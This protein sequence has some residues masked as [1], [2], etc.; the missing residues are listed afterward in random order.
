[1]A[2][3]L[4]KAGYITGMFGKWHLGSNDQHPS[5]RGFDKAIMSAGAH[6]GFKTDPSLDHDPDQYLSDF[7][8]DNALQFIE[9]SHQSEKPFFLYFPD[10]LVHK[11][12]DAKP[13]YLEYFEKKQNGK[14]HKSSVAAAM[15]KSL[16]DT[17]GRILKK[18]AELGI[19]EETFVVF[20]SDNGGLDY[21][22]DGEKEKNT[23]NHPLRGRKGTEWEG[24]MRVPYI[25]RWPERIPGG[26]V[27]KHNIINVD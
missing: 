24:G 26:S 6:Y 22:E 8:C 12:L 13:E 7:L 9:E 21:I 18:L 1:M 5:E 10:F 16:D 4:K 2:E 3:T 19:E 25:F 23:S 20:T 27:S 14:Y 17:V 15:T 11:P